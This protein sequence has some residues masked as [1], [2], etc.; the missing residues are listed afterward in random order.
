[1]GRELRLR[2][3]KARRLLAAAVVSI[4]AIGPE[5]AARPATAQ[6]DPPKVLPGKWHG[7]IMG[8]YSGNRARVLVINTV[9]EVTADGRFGVSEDRLGRIQISVLRSGSG[10][11]LEFT[12][13]VREVIIPW[14]LA[15]VSERVLT[16]T[17]NQ[18]VRGPAG[19]I[20][21]P[22]KFEKVE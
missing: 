8:T 9:H 4:V 21:F 10:V 13:A 17:V 5:L 11:T 18:P 15:L 20:E 14:R 2:S 19:R 7:E 1:M 22:V 6:L 3:A 12:T 16:G